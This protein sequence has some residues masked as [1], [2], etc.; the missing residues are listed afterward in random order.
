MQILF[1]FRSCVHVC[2]CYR[3]KGG[4]IGLTTGKW[5]HPISL[6]NGRKKDP[7]ERELSVVSIKYI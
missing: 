5:T 2:P 3:G 1:L 6:E 4:V 7:L